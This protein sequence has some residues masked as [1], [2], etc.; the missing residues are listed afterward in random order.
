MGQPQT[1]SDFEYIYES[2]TTRVTSRVQPEKIN[3]ILA[4]VATFPCG[5]RRAKFTMP[6]QARE[7]R[8]SVEAVASRISSDDPAH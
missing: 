2:N 8:R 4:S 7:R 3:R 6:R 5:Q 1:P